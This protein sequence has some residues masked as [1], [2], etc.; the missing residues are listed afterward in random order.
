MIKPYDYQK[1]FSKETNTK[2]RSNSNASSNFSDNELPSIECESSNLYDEY[3]K[4]RIL[5]LLFSPNWHSLNAL[6]SNGQ[7][8]IRV[9]CTIELVK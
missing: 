3:C 1:V 8:S 6:T 4:L 7:L 2:S 9:F 5:K